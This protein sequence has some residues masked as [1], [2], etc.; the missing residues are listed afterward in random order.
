MKVAVHTISIMG[1]LTNL[2]MHA[3]IFPFR[4]DRHNCMKR[5]VNERKFGKGLAVTN[6]GS[7]TI[8][9]VVKLRLKT[10]FNRTTI[11]LFS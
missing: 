3:N 1:S 10:Y 6:D 11:Y 5:K 2:I 8:D 9:T 7:Q 4:Q